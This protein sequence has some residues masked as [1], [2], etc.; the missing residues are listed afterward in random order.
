V[1]TQRGTMRELFVPPYRRRTVMMTVFH[2]LQTWGYYGFGTLAP[3]VL[4]AKGYSVVD[5]LLFSSLTY[6][7]YPL[8]SILSVPLVER[9]ERKY[10]V[11]GAAL[12]MAA[13]GLAFGLAGSAPTIVLCGFVYTMVSNVFSNAY[14][15]YQAEVFPTRLRATAT[16]STYSLSR[17]SSGLMPFILLPLLHS[18]GAGALFMVVALALVIV[19]L[20][21]ALLGPRTTGR[22]LESV[23]AISTYPARE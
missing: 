16:S 17:L 4:V 3:L 5:S 9:I 14:H 11:V 22:A 13:F 1:P 21:I 19:A 2:L 10:L 20:D 6:L 12:G 7:G 18:D 23:N 8:G 15:I